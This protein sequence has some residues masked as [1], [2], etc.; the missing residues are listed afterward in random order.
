MTIVEPEPTITKGA[1]LM[2]H[3]ISE[4]KGVGAP[5]GCQ[6]QAGSR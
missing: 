6:R 2:D 3:A 1:N 5:A 4:A